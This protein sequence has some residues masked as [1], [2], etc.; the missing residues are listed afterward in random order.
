[1]PIGTSVGLCIGVR[2]GNSLS[3]R[4]RSRIRIRIRLRIGLGLVQHKY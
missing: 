1:M 2:I 3:I 4:S